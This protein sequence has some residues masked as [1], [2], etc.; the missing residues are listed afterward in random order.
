M[1]TITISVLIFVSV[2]TVDYMRTKPPKEFK[3]KLCDVVI[4]ILMSLLEATMLSL[5]IIPTL[6][7]LLGNR[8]IIY[9]HVS[10]NKYKVTDSYHL[11][12]EN[13]LKIPAT[14]NDTISYKIDSK[15]YYSS[16]K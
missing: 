16:D 8:V 3:V 2:F 9:T 1:I 14:H 4:N 13:L 12:R 10:D 6:G 7:L 11:Y 15:Y 5:I